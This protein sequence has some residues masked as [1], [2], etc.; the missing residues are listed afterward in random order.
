MNDPSTHFALCL[1][2]GGY[3]ASLEVGKLYRVSEAEALYHP[4]EAHL[5]VAT[6]QTRL[7]AMETANT[8]VTAEAVPLSNSRIDRNDILYDNDDNLCDRAGLVK[9]YVKSLYGASSPQYSQVRG[10]EFKK[11]K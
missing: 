11:V 7:A 8:D 5:Q 2:N 10:L 9:K 4:N 6:L 1:N 3:Q